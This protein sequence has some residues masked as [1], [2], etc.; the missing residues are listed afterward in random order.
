MEI[1]DY[2]VMNEVVFDR[3]PTPYAIQIEIHIDD[4]YV[5]TLVGDG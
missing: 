5:T 2:H 3:G 4:T 1:K